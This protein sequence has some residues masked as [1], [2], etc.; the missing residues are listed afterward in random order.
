MAFNIPKQPYAGMIGETTLGKGDSALTM[1][2]QNTYPFHLF[3]GETPNAPKIA[4]EVWDY[5]PSEE[6]PAAAIEPFKDVIASPDA[7]A[8]KNVEENGADMIVLQL[9]STDPNGLDRGADEAAKVAKKVA[10]AVDVPLILWGTANNNKDEEVLKKIS[11]LCEGMNVTLGPVEEGNYKGVAAS[12]MGYNHTIISSSP[13]DVNLAKQLNILLT[14]LGLKSDKIIIDPT[15]GGL[16]YGLE[17]SYSVMERILMAALTQEDDKLQFPMINNVG[18]EVWKSKEAKQ[19]I[20][21]APTSGDPEKKGIMMETVAAVAYLLAGSSIVIL[22]H[23]ESVRLVRSFIDLMINGGSAGD[24]AGINKL[25]DIQE[26]DL[27]ALAPEPNLEI[28]EDKKAPKAKAAPKQEKKAAPE[29]KVEEVKAAPPKPAAEPKTEVKVDEK[30]KAELEAKAKAEA[31]LKAKEEAETKAEAEAKA[32]VELE[33]KAEAEAKAAA[34]LKAKAEAKAKAEEIAGR[35]A[36]EAD[37]RQQR[38]KEK[39][40]LAAKR[41]A[42]TKS[43]AAKTVSSVKKTKLEKMMGKLNKRNKR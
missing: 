29:P 19:T 21:E 33:A 15:T 36:E 26:A 1:G 16:G 28:P 30:A 23:P 32:K 12:A 42:T 18:N 40:D 41:A 10:D 3:E 35:D 20:D 31:E 24:V 5:D 17:Y 14:N 9:K 11:E 13:I 27:I 38:A 34:E 43:K 2:G 39:E 22:R 8:K 7:W 25:L 37:L 6:W 4:M